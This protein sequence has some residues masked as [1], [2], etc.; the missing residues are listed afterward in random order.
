MSFFEGL[1][2]NDV[3]MVCFT[4]WFIAQL[5]KVV[6][7]FV[8]EKKIDI[9]RFVGSGGMPS[10]HSSFVTSLATGVG[11]KKGYDSVEFALSLVL[12]L[13]VMY[14]AAGVRRAVGKQAKILNKMIEDIHAHKKDIFTEKRLKELIGHTPVEV[15]SGAILG[16][17]IANIMI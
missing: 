15:I 14:D 17:V 11:I 4:A 1:L 16:I 3:F 2:N 13:I 10:S 7:T 12:A 9:S 6:I 8:F 5:L